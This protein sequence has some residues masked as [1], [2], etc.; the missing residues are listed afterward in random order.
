MSRLFLCTSST[1]PS[2]PVIGDTWLETD[3]NSVIV[4][5][6][7]GWAVYSLQ[8]VGVGSNSNGTESQDDGFTNDP[9][10]P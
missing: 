6:P 7:L 1:R 8:N 2:D 9:N 5:G 4:Y 3:T 10:T